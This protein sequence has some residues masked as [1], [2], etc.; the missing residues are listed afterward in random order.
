M[1][2]PLIN[3]LAII[4]G[5]KAEMEVFLKIIEINWQQVNT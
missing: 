1:R 2:H 3:L 4:H 5:T